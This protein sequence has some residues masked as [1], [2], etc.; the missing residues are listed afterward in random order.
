MC[1]LTG[2]EGI[3]R[4]PLR[5]KPSSEVPPFIFNQLVRA[6]KSKR[7]RARAPAPALTRGL[8]LGKG[9]NR[10]EPQFPFYESRDN[11]PHSDELRKLTVVQEEISA[12]VLT[13]EEGYLVGKKGI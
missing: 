4:I 10:F 8:T 9:F 3:P 7:S 5:K 6:R 2:R 12:S 1:P 13:E 11:F